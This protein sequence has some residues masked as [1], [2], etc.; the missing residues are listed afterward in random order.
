MRT[1]RENF[2]KSAV[3]LALSITALPSLVNAQPKSL[4]SVNKDKSSNKSDLKDSVKDTKTGVAK[5]IDITLQNGV[6][7]NVSSVLAAVIGLP[8]AMP[9][10]KHEVVMGQSDNDV[11]TR[12]CYVIYD[13]T[14]SANPEAAE[15]RATCAYIV[16]IKR[17]GLDKQT[18]Y[19]RIDLNGKL[20]KVVL[21]Q[22]KFDENG[23]IVRGSGVK[24]DLDINSPEVKKT[25]DAEMKFWLKDWLKKQQKAPAKKA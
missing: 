7:S 10:K 6:E 3:V 24:T 14:A 12:A 25:F 8:N 21:S 19:F 18:R 17:S 5:L 15:K 16:R 13:N 22:S 1:I 23:K 2:R 9:M 11:E 4:T 20:E